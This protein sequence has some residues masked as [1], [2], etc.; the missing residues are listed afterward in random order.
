LLYTPP[1]AGIDEATPQ[2]CR[3]QLARGEEATLGATAARCQPVRQPRSSPESPPAAQYQYSSKTYS[4]AP[5][6]P[7]QIPKTEAIA[8]MLKNLKTLSIFGP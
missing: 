8:S 1:A 7:F 3:R 5:G 4:L 2:G 6:I